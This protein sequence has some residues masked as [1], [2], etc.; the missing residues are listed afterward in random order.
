MDAYTIPEAAR[1]AGLTPREVRMRIEEGDLRAFIRAGRRMVAH[2]EIERLSER[3]SP[4]PTPAAPNPPIDDLVARL[5][6]QA[7][8]LARVKRTAAETR[9]RDA[10]EVRSLEQDLGEARRALSRAR[11]RIAELESDGAPVAAR[12]PDQREALTPLFRRTEPTPG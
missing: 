1:A 8:E 10:A 7:L 2:S 4:P 5:E 6:E 3:T 9:A 12:P 11:E